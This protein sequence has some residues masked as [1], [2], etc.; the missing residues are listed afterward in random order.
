MN[1]EDIIVELRKKVVETFGHRVSTTTDFNNLSHEIFMK[2]KTQVSESTLKRIWKYVNDTPNPRVTTLDILSQYCG[3]ENFDV[4]SE[5]AIRVWQK[6]SKLLNFND[7]QREQFRIMEKIF[8]QGSH[9]VCFKMNPKYCGNIEVVSDGIKIYSTVQVRTPFIKYR[10]VL[11]Y[12]YII[13]T[14]RGDHNYFYDVDD[15]II[16]KYNCLEDLVTDG[17]ELD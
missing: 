16:I 11:D 3:Y 6:S 10:D 8:E 17:W 4:F 5:E 2:C 7:H 12:K 13:R 14:M 15:P 1:I 9:I